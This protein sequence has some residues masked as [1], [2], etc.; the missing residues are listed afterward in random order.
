MDSYDSKVKGWLSFNLQGDNTMDWQE[1]ESLSKIFPKVSRRAVLATLGAGAAAVSLG[2]CASTSMQEPVADDIRLPD[3]A[4]PPVPASS[5]TPMDTGYSPPANYVMKV[6]Y[7]RPAHPASARGPL[8]V[9]PRSAW[10]S[11]GPA[12]PTI[13]PM[14]GVNLITF[15]HSG[16][17]QPFLEDSVEG[18]A[19]YLEAIRHWQVSQGFQDI[20]YHFANDRMGRIWQL[21]ELKYRGEHVRDGFAWPRWL[22]T[23]VQKEN[24]PTKPV[25]GR[26]IWNA[27]NIGIVTLGNFMIQEPTEYQKRRIVEFG[28]LVRT[29]Y[30][31]PIYHCYTHQEL[32]A[33][34][35]PGAK[36][37]PYME[38][39]RRGGIM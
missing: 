4:L 23:Y 35:C 16:D 28:R 14:D 6:P 18:T 31:I 5:P 25:K 7:N 34:L 11:A 26:F 13:Q 12:L 8:G 15:H 20:A 9:I 30:Q 2:G 10:T 19:R 38:Y 22:D 32:V 17:P 39:I 33:T 1:S 27:H 37:Q 36:Y 3:G 24:S 21:R 29:L